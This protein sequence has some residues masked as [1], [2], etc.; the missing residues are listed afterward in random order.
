MRA[1]PPGRVAEG[2]GSQMNEKRQTKGGQPKMAADIDMKEV[3]DGL[4][5]FFGFTPDERL[6]RQILAD[7]TAFVGKADEWGWDDTEVRGEL[8]EM[9]S[10]VLTGHRWPS[11]GEAR[12]QGI[13]I[14]EFH[15]SV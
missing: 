15:R 9:I 10:E 2:T 14:D 4:T 8:A 5:Y 7:H 1:A 12:Q 6:L 3:R 11:Y 13:D